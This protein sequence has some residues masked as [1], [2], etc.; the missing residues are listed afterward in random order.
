M[1]W[2]IKIASFEAFPADSFVYNEPNDNFYYHVTTQSK[3]PLIQTKGLSITT[4]PTVKGWYE[5]YSKGKIFFCEKEAVAFWRDRIEEHLDA[6]FDNPPKVVVVR[7][8]KN[9]IQNPQ[10]DEVGTQDSHH[11]SYFTNH[12]IKQATNDWEYWF[13]DP[14]KQEIKRD[15]PTSEPITISVYRGFT[16]NLEELHRENDSFILSPKKSEQKAI[17]FSR[18][19]QDAQGRGN[20]LLTYPLQAIKHFQRVYYSDGDYHDEIPE[21]IIQQTKPTENCK[22][23]GGI[24]LPDGWFFSY[25]VQKYIISTNPI[26]I[27]FNMIQPDNSN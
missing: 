1:N 26:K 8:P 19:I 24:E 17:W 12:P 21:E 27:T 9:M 2:L 5:Q 14:P 15:P 7:F 23:S 13:N 6:S 18:N 16:A 11:P 4:Q 20:L 3:L 25:K 22:F 10:I